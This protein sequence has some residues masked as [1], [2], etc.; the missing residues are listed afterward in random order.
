MRY[1]S[2]FLTVALCLTCILYPLQSDAIITNVRDYMPD[3]YWIAD[4]NNYFTTD[5]VAYIDGMAVP[6][7]NI[8]GNT[9]VV[10]EDL[11][12][13]GFNVIWNSEDRTISVFTLALPEAKPNYVPQKPEGI[14][15]AIGPVYQ[16][17]IIAYVNDRKTISYNIG[18]RTA[19]VLEDMSGRSPDIPSGFFAIDQNI[20][21]EQGRYSDSC[22]RAE[23]DSIARA[24]S[25]YCL[26]P[27][28]E[29]ETNLGS[30]RIYGEQITSTS[31]LSRDAFIEGV[32]YPENNLM[33]VLEVREEQNPLNEFW[34][35]DIEDL[36]S[37]LGVKYTYH[38]GIIDID[39]SSLGNNI[40]QGSMYHV[41]MKES[42]QNLLP[43][44]ISIALDGKVKV[45]PNNTA[46][47][48]EYRGKVMVY[49]DLL[50]QATGKNLFQH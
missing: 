41:G 1:K 6:S 26:R 25:L 40:F 2:I 49:T 11:V 3:R 28:G 27:G 14:G 42:T 36:L 37:R 38:D 47:A 8:G 48:Y 20:H 13:Y 7:Y 35:Y 33:Q 46:V 34:Y 4:A 30:A 29:I 17:D 19:I 44:D 43:L 22:M 21:Y 10:S 18:G 24:I 32:E 50:N 16:T 45:T 5:I 31:Y 15:V 39:S 23:W 12:P 9:V